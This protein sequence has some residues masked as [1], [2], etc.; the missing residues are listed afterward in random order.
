MQAFAQM[1]RREMKA[2]GHSQADTARLSS[3]SQP[4]V[5]AYLKS[6]RRPDLYAFARLLRVYPRL[7]T[8]LVDLSKDQT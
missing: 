2:E 3:L 1:L 6:K 7:L 8:W 5:S 4:A